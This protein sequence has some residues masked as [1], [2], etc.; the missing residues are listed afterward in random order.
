MNFALRR[1]ARKV[2][3]IYDR[4]F[5]KAGIRSTQFSVLLTLG[6]YGDVGVTDLADGLGLD[7][8]T[9]SK[10]LRP[11]IRRD[12]VTTVP[13]SDKRRRLLHLTRRG[14]EMI[15]KVLPHWE[16]AQTLVETAVGKDE[17]REL[18]RELSGIA[19]MSVEPGDIGRRRGREAGQKRPR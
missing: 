2:T 17:A 7:R 1:A 10:N 12:L 19:R 9:L 15:G 3:L 13:A 18:R 14:T 8:T 16:E 6:A 11:L 5:A 4:A